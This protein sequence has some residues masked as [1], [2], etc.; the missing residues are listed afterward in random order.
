MTTKEII[1]F[2]ALAFAVILLSTTFANAQIKLPPALQQALQQARQ[3]VQLTPQEQQLS[4]CP[5]S[6]LDSIPPLKPELIP[7]CVGSP[8]LPVGLVPPSLMPPAGVPQPFAQLPAI[9][10]E[11]QKA[12]A[13][14]YQV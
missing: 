14:D 11:I 3:H 6:Y 9:Q 8:K 1:T 12:L 13:A 10:Q 7:L 2:P 4:N 5:T